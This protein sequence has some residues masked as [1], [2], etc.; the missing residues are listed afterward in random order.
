MP[1]TP[2]STNPP[3]MSPRQ[4]KMLAF[5]ERNPGCSRRDVAESEPGVTEA[6]CYGIIKRLEARGSI[7][8][9]RKAP[10]RRVSRLYI[11]DAGRPFAG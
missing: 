1:P 9:V 8:D 7:E 6:T 10:D 5:I 11:T 4:R 2:P 3:Y